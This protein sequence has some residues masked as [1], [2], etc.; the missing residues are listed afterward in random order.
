MK[1][2]HSSKKINDIQSCGVGVLASLITMV[3]LIAVIAICIKNEYLY[4][5][6]SD[7]WMVIVQFA[8]CV[9]GGIIAGRV[10]GNEKL[11]AAV[12]PAV[13]LV[14]QVLTALLLFGEISSRL[15]MILITTCAAVGAGYF[16]TIVRTKRGATKR[17]IRHR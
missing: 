16:L 14:L 6:N 11:A 1:K 2:Y 15:W 5:R 10:G 8:S 13:I 3:V 4:I 9:F 7:Y 12:V 17:K